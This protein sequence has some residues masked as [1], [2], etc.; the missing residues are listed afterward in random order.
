MQYRGANDTSERNLSWLDGTAISDLS[1]DGQQFA[2]ME[3]MNAAGAWPISYIR[4]AD[5][6]FAV[7]LGIGLW[8]VLS[9]D[10]KWAL[11]GSYAPPHLALLPTGAGEARSLN[12]Y[13]LQQ[14]QWQGWMPD[15]KAV[16][17][18]GSDGHSWRMYLQNIDAGAPR[19]VTP[20]MAVNASQNLTDLVSPDGKFVF[21]RDLNGKG[22]LYPLSGGQP[23]PVSGL[24]PGDV[25]VNWT[26]DGKAIYVYQDKT[27][28][29]DL[30]RLELSDGKR[31]FLRTLAPSDSAGLSGAEGIRITPDGKSYAYSYTRALSTLY[32]VDG[33]K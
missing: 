12:N 19:P 4:K 3:F 10:G 21:A 32:L 1:P 8:P 31:Q 20:G 17:F 2:F 11:V 14:F 33:V 23:S 26:S 27:T 18:A 28:H 30:F 16:Y 15:G 7:K 6:P 25:W 5:D 29:F 9:P 22:W 13:G 24:L